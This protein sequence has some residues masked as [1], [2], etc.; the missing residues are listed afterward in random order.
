MFSIMDKNQILSIIGKFIAYSK[1]S[2]TDVKWYGI[3][4]IAALWAGITKHE[5][6][7][8]VQDSIPVARS[9]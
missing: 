4:P 7:G 8:D 5:S 9:F 3:K 1:S 2:P 6:I